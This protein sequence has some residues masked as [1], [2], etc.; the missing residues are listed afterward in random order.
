MKHVW[1]RNKSK[2]N[3][4]T[5]VFITITISIPWLSNNNRYCRSA[6]PLENILKDYNLGPVL[7]MLIAQIYR[8]YRGKTYDHLIDMFFASHE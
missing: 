4:E 5:S 1:N 8:N 3:D 7:Y 6:I 2:V